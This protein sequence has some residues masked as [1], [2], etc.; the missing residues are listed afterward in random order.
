M[1]GTEEWRSVNSVFSKPHAFKFGDI[2][3]YREVYNM[4]V[5]FAGDFLFFQKKHNPSS[6]AGFEA[7]G[8]VQK[9]S[10][11]RSTM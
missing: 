2:I 1:K 7:N 9:N 10:G 6:D 5:G 11:F 3:R 4:S 8:I